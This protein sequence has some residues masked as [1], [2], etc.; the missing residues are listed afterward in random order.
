MVEPLRL[1]G[2]DLARPRPRRS[3]HRDRTR[4]HRPR[5]AGRR[6]RAARA[7]PHFPHEAASA[8]DGRLVLRALSPDA[9][10]LRRRVAALLD[11]LR[12]GPLPRVWQ[13]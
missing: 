1:P 3:R 4:H 11:H 6:G 10:A 12:G 7:A 8:W 9:H 13:T 2:E 5:R